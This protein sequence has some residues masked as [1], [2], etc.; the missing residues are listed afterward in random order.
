MNRQS[1]RVS[2]GFTFVEILAALLFLAIVIPAIVTGLTV[3]NRAAVISERGS[4]AVQMGE[5]RLSE[6]VATGE[7]QSAETQGVFG[8]EWPG[9]RWELTQKA[10]ETDTMTELTMSVFYPVQGAERRVDLTT[11]VSETT[12]DGV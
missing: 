3:S 7:W 4:I 9:Y 10:W 5:N 12:E 1:A 8:E 2:G 6:L 11:L